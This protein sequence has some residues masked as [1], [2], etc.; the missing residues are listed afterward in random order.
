MIEQLKEVIKIDDEFNEVHYNLA[1]AYE[2]K[3]M[4]D[5]AVSEYVRELEINPGYASAH[6]NLGIL[7]RS[8][9]N[10]EKTLYHW[11]RYLELNPDARDAGLIRKE[12]RKLREK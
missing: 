3:G 1:V 8:K 10:N 6:K 9:G 2:K 4:F 5:E 7:Y 11:E 12:I